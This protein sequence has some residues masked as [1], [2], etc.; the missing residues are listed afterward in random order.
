MTS[1]SSVPE[2]LFYLVWF[3]A[4][5]GP[6]N[7]EL[8]PVEP[9]KKGYWTAGSVFWPIRRGYRNLWPSS[10]ALRSG[11]RLSLLLGFCFA[12]AP[13]LLQDF[14]PS[15]TA[16]IPQGWYLV[17]LGVVAFFVGR[18]TGFWSADRRIAKP[19]IKKAAAEAQTPGAGRQ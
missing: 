15:V 1:L 5:F 17:E 8:E 16:A 9:P 18:A 2:Y 13:R 7:R 12:A 14:A 10:E 4:I 6:G 11:L 19:D 3:I